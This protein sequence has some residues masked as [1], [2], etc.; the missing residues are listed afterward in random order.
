MEPAI[1][2]G[3]RFVC[4][5]HLEL[6]TEK[7]LDQSMLFGGGSFGA[8]SRTGV[9]YHPGYTGKLRSS[10]DREASAPTGSRKD[11]CFVQEICGHITTILWQLAPLK[12]QTCSSSHL[13][14]L[15]KG[16]YFSR[17]LRT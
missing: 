10:L 15:A 9:G 5:K 1:N 4:N 6:E 14:D 2:I 17:E 8:K 12:R 3:A 11:T 16:P 7:R 13:C